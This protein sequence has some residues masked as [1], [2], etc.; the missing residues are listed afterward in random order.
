MNTAVSIGKITTNSV[1]NAWKSFTTYPGR[2]DIAASLN[3]VI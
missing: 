2:S 1:W 3:K